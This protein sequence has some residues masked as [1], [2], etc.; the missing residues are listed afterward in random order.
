MAQITL[1]IPDN[2][3]Q[4]VIEAVCRAGTPSWPFFPVTPVEP[5]VTAAQAKA[6]VVAWVKECV[7]QYELQVASAAIVIDVA[8]VAS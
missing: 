7:H 3:V 1:T 8:E 4:R 2:Q 6:Q 5:V